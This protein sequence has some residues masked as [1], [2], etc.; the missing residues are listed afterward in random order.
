[1]EKLICLTLSIMGLWSLFCGNWIELIR[2]KRSHSFWSS[3]IWVSLS[4]CKRH[5]RSRK[6]WVMANTFILGII[7]R[8]IVILTSYLVLIELTSQISLLMVALARSIVAVAFILNLI[9]SLRVPN[10][11]INWRGMKIDSRFAF[12]FC[13][14]IRWVSFAE[15]SFRLFP[16]GI[17]LLF[18]NVSCIVSFQ[19]FLALILFFL[20]SSNHYLQVWQANLIVSLILFEYG[21]P[22]NDPSHLIS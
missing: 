15:W 13:T 3:L 10:M 2:A 7:G 16:R 20:V 9:V 14:T 19:R 18:T 17:L 4:P 22:S 8:I 12:V 21:D 11:R 1:M 6:R 5:F